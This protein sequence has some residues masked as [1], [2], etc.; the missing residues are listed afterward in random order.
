MAGD[1]VGAAEVERY[2]NKTDRPYIH[3]TSATAVHSSSTWAPVIIASASCSGYPDS[4]FQLLAIKGVDMMG[5]ARKL[6]EAACA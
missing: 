3:I 6:Y 5:L 1:G 4:R 2:Q